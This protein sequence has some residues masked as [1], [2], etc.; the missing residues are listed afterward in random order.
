MF[1]KDSTNTANIHDLIIPGTTRF[2]GLGVGSY[3]ELW[4]TQKE[5]TSLQ[6]LPIS[7]VHSN[8][9]TGSNRNTGDADAVPPRELRGED[10]VKIRQS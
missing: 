7:N 2:L 8:D 9:T 4:G 3:G 1:P 6:P 10:Q 5:V